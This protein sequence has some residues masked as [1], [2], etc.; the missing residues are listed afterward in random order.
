MAHSS[1]ES[2][3]QEYMIR[4]ENKDV[5]IDLKRNRSGTYLKIAERSGGSRNTVLIPASGIQR[6]RAVL[7]EVALAIT[8]SPKLIRYVFYR[9]RERARIGEKRGNLSCLCMAN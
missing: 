6:L 1:S 8:E 2:T 9:E 4:V 5:F 7:D 3:I